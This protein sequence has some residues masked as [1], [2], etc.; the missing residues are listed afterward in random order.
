M[1]SRLASKCLAQKILFPQPSWE[2]GF[3]AQATASD[4]ET[5]PYILWNLEP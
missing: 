3:Q 2:L 4:P 5:L 1:L